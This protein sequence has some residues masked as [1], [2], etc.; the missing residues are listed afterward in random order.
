MSLHQ[1]YML[2][3]NSLEIYWRHHV[4]DIMLDDILYM[5]S[6]IDFQTILYKHVKLV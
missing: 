2:V 5:V 3:Q 1:F 6:S 4:Q